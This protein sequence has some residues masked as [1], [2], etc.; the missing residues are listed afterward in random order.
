M[1]CIYPDVG[2][3]SVPNETENTLA[4]IS[5]R[6]MILE[7]FRTGTGIRFRKGS[8]RKIGMDQDTLEAFTSGRFIVDRARSQTLASEDT[9]TS[10]GPAS[11]I[12]HRGGLG[13]DGSLN[14]IGKTPGPIIATKETSSPT[15]T[16]GA[17]SFKPEQERKDAI[18]PIYDQLDICKFWWLSELIPLRHK[19]QGV[20]RSPQGHYWSCVSHPYPLLIISH[21]HF[22]HSVNNG[23]SRRIL[24]PAQEGERVLVHRSVDVRMKAAESELQGGKKY[25]PRAEFNPLEIEW[26]D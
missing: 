10:A 13:Q 15:T 8:L 4:R 21:E 25:I 11:A 3:G 20:E 24:K 16:S 18:S 1:L 2:G 14:S 17:L 12:E 26:V 22:S 5:L 19:L 23:R 6:W 7:C 9:F